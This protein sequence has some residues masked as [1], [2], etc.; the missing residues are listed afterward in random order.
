MSE[1]QATAAALWIA[2][3]HAFDAADAT[4]Y[5]SI[6]SVEKESGKT[7]TLEVLDELVARP[8]L[9]GRVTAAVLARKWTPSARRCS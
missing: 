7:R 1:A 8:W 3:T 9:T 5:L 4:P 6:T 2:H